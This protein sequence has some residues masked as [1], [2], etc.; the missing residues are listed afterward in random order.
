MILGQLL[1]LSGPL[2][3]YSQLTTHRMLGLQDDVV[4]MS[5]S[6]CAGVRGCLCPPSTQFEHWKCWGCPVGKPAPPLLSSTSHHAHR[7]TACKR[8]RRRL[9]FSLN[10]CSLGPS[11]L[12][13]APSLP[14]NRSPQ[15]PSTYLSQSSQRVFSGT[16]MP[17]P[18]A[19]GIISKLLWLRPASTY[20]SPAFPTH[21]PCHPNFT[22]FFCLCRIL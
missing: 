13:G 21:L 9:N 22:I 18:T 11:S 1:P 4:E 3:Q 16:P 7:V 17:T 10:L 5:C 2:T 15:Y 20:P 12:E 19:T 6:W 8:L 14:P